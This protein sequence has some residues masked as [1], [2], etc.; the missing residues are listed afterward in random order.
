MTS[1]TTR[2]APSTRQGAAAEGVPVPRI[3]TSAPHSARVWDYWLGGRENY[4]VDREVGDL[5]AE[6]LPGIVDAAR[7]HRAFLTRAV[8]FMAGQA[9]IAQFLDIGTGLPT[10]DNTHEVAQR[11]RRDARIVYVDNDPLVLV[12]AQALLTSSPAGATGYLD[13]DVRNPEQIL[14]QATTTLDFDRP[15]GLLLLNILHHITDDAQA[16]QIVTNLLGG[17]AAGSM[18]AIGWLTAAVD[19][20][21]MHQA[22]DA[23]T[24]MGGDPI[25]ARPPEEL[26]RF[27][28][29]LELLEP[30]V[31]SCSRW[32][33]DPTPFG[34]D[35]EVAQFCGVARKARP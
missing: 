29:G 27:F 26:E 30:G 11:A 34:A 7:H 6:L 23:W 3:D 31:V 24:G 22:L 1:A 2:P 20:Q 9:G 8:G 18:V 12:H 21:V 28:G 15:V 17:L 19:G 16:H 13:A 10:V 33:P 32:R 14:A 35:P 4:P 25:V 5:F